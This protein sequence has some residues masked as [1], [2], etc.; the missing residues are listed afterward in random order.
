MVIKLRPHPWVGGLALEVIEFDQ[1][2]SPWKGVQL[3]LV[4]D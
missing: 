3:E 1:G 4:G 2:R